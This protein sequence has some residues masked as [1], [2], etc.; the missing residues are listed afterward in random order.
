MHLTRFFTCEFGIRTL[1][2]VAISAMQLLLVTHLG[3]YFGAHIL[4]IAEHR[5]FYQLGKKALASLEIMPGAPD[6]I[7]VTLT[8]PLLYVGLKA[9]S[10]RKILFL[11]SIFFLLLKN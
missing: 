10:I 5:L 8:S 7:S 4:Y 3:G 11:F 1:S 6:S 2:F 9:I